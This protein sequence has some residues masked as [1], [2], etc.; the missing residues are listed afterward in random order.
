MTGWGDGIVPG[1][2]AIAE[3]YPS[4]RISTMATRP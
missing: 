3:E 2:D 4:R 1:H